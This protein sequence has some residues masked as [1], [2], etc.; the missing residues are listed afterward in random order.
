MGIKLL[1][2]LFLGLSTN[3]FAQTE[4][5]EFSRYINLKEAIQVGLRKN[6]QQNIRDRE[7]TINRLQWSNNYTK[8]WFPEISFVGSTSHRLQ[9]LKNNRPNINSTAN[10]YDGPNGYIG[11]ELKDYS[12]FNWGKDYL[13]YQSDKA[14]YQRKIQSLSELRRALRFKIIMSFFQFVKNDYISKIYR[15][16]VKQTSFIQRV[17]K[18]RFDLRRGLKKDYLQAQTEYL[19]SQIL[20]QDAKIKRIESEQVLASILDEPFNSRF[21]TNEQLQFIRVQ[22]PQ[23]QLVK[24]TLKN[25][26]MVSEARFKLENSYRD[27]KITQKSNMPLPEIKLSLGTYKWGISNNGRETYW[28]NESYSND[29]EILAILSFEWNIF[30]DGGLFNHRDTQI[31]YL[32]KTVKEIEY[33]DIKTQVENNVKS[34]FF[35]KNIIEKKFEIARLQVKSATINYEQLIDH[36]MDGKTDYIQLKTALEQLITAKIDLEHV[37]YEH[38]VLKLQLAQNSGLD[39]LPGKKFELLAIQ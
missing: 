33:F 16:K 34:M 19:N 32:Q 4:Q 27:Y 39:D 37:K 1:T 15:Q 6:L 28:D 3:G 5:K 7:K 29:F 13:Q 22:I 23:A 11:V 12:L 21:Y 9:R 8:F 24:E 10:S 38:L 14:T 36:Y 2:T 31:A 25:N 26:P 20:Y 30:G 17:A 35:K 18:K